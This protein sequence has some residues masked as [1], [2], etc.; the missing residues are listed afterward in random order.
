MS[1]NNVSRRSV[2]AAGATGLGISLAGCSGGSGGSDGPTV[3]ILEDRSG[4]FQL[5]GTSKW[6]ATRLAIEEINEEGG[7]LGEQVEIVDPDPQSDNQRYQELT[8]RLILQDEVDALW[9]GYSSATREAIRPIINENEQLYFYTTQYEGG[10][11][12]N[13]IFPVGATARQQLGIVTPYLADQYGEDI[14]IVAADYNFGQLSGDWVNVLAQEN[15]Y[16]IVG[17]EYIPLS[18]TDFSSVINRI[19][20]EDPDFIMSMLVGAN[21]ENFY[22]QRATNDLTIPVGTSTAM[23]QGFEHKRY[24]P[25]ALTDVYCGVSYM[26]ELGDLREGENFVEDFYT[27]WPDANYLNQEAQNNYFSVYLWA[28]AVEEAGTFDQEAV[29]EVL[30]Q[31]RDISAPSGELTLDGATHHMEHEMRVAHAD[32][33]HEIS[34]TNNERIGP[35]FLREEVEGGAGCDLREED[36]TT[37]YVP[38]DVY[39]V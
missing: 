9:A 29:I 30:E 21:H 3:G 31:G 12:D 25:P 11:C 38:S 16:N 14:Y 17:E 26:E 18:E 5:N 15:D 28:E 27:R 39:D 22:D 6:Q 23:A 4:N 37:Q 13:T 10:V 8:E 20:Q 35:S 32:E 36:K 24:D 34:F 1:Y 2:L 7:I 19:Q 33:N